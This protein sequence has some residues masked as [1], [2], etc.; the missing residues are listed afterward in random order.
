MYQ[1]TFL[2]NNTYI[3]LAIIA[4][5][6]LTSLSSCKNPGLDAAYMEDIETW[7]ARRL[8]S[9]KS[10]TGWTT[11]AGLFW[12]EKGLNSLGS[13]GTNTIILPENMPAHL[14]D[15]T[16]TG[17][18]LYFK[19][20]PAIRITVNGD[21]FREGPVHTD[22]DGDAEVFNWQRYTWYFIRRG[23]RTGLRLRDTLHPARMALHAIPAF[24]VSTKYIFQAVYQ[25]P[26]VDETVE[27]KNVI[28]NTS[29]DPVAG[30]LYFTHRKEEHLLTA[31][32]GGPISLWLIFS[33]ETTGAE[34]YGGGRYLYVSRPDS[35]GMVTIDFNKAYNPPC[36][37]TDYATCPLP[38]RENHLSFKVRAGEKTYGHH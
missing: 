22:M 23:D 2:K 20:D 17:D 5:I 30:K 11:L 25:P 32:D 36:A 13:A 21:I 27:I 15:L 4:F 12:M 31:L 10:K 8:A 19:T 6:A 34:T 35:N 1:V 18:S 37:F 24:P 3:K 16:L 38:P 26:Q 14:G 9:L 28:G 29:E 33:D 7:R